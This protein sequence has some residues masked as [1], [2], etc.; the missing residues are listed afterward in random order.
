MPSRSVAARSALRSGDDTSPRLGAA[1]PP[2]GS[3]SAPER[4]PSAAVQWQATRSCR[5]PLAGRPPD[6]GPPS[7][8]TH[9]PMTD[10]LTGTPALDAITAALATVQDPEINRPLTELGMLKDVQIGAPG[11]P[12]AVRVDVYL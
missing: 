1:A 6:Q 10:T 12:G 3:P 7:K 8:E 4:R 5:S 9:A 2:P 11:D